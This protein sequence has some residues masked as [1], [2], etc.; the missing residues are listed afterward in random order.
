MLL[1]V[2]VIVEDLQVSPWYGNI[3]GGV[4]F[5]VRGPIFNPG[6]SIWCQFN[7]LSIPCQ[8]VD[9]DNAM[10]ISP[11]LTF[12]RRITLRL[13]TNNEKYNTDSRFYSCKLLYN[14]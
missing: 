12:T 3:L 10:C 13:F 8:R 2:V 14:N 7:E 11:R 6:D 4:P 9:D 1:F 5:I